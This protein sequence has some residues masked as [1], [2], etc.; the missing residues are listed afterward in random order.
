[1]SLPLLYFIFMLVAAAHALPIAPLPSAQTSPLVCAFVLLPFPLLAAIK[2]TYL[3]HRRGQ[4][5]H[6]GI[7]K[8]APVRLLGSPR[9]RKTILGRIHSGYLIG[10]LGSPD[11]ETRIQCRIDKVERYM[12]QSPAD[13]KPS[14][15]VLY[16][17]ILAHSSRTSSRNR[18]TPNVSSHR[19]LSRSRSLSVSC[20]DLQSLEAPVDITSCAI[21]H[22]SSPACPL[23]LSRPYLAHLRLRRTPVFS[24]PTLMQIMEPVLSSWYDETSSKSQDSQ[25]TR[26]TPPFETPPTSPNSEA[27]PLT[28]QN[29]S[30]FRKD[31]TLSTS[32]SLL[33]G[34]R[35]S[36]TVSV[37]E[38][39]STP[40]PPPVHAAQS[41]RRSCDALPG[42]WTNDSVEQLRLLQSPTYR[43]PS[44]PLNI[45]VVTTT[46]RAPFAATTRPLNV[47]PKPKTMS[48]PS[49]TLVHS[50]SPLDLFSGKSKRGKA[51]SLQ[52]RKS[53][54]PTIGPSPLRH[55]V[56]IETSV[57]MPTFDSR[58]MSGVY[59][60]TPTTV[61]STTRA[62]WELDD[63][64]RDGQ[65]DVDAV[66]AALGLGLVM[67]LGS[68]SG[69][70]IPSISD[71]T[72]SDA[73]YLS[74]SGSP[75]SGMGW[76]RAREVGNITLQI[77]TPG[78]QLCAI[79]EEDDIVSVA[80]R[81][82]SV[83]SMLDIDM[84]LQGVEQDRQLATRGDSFFGS[85]T[86]LP[87]APSASDGVEGTVWEDE[88]SWRD[89][90]SFR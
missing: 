28:K 77:R 49:P 65:L 55:S 46:Y 71:S 47:V 36:L 85:V 82:H 59:L 80:S 22:P 87:Q 24:S 10:C 52:R 63:L 11:W 88:Q 54:S 53:G 4:S 62:S 35:S 29:A 86:T 18:T 48:P 50:M 68:L 56:A 1:M 42:D 78:A 58:P 9:P 61:T 13:P 73:V 30:V 17:R 3:R 67:G 51:M 33:I 23:L 64:V 44:T 32:S 12:R 40:V 7:E 74:S 45:E 60:T 8:M 83:G 16:S 75:G 14:S 81:P 2:Y 34:D 66:S 90:V 31:I 6:E 89:T 37:F 43:S 84:R 15:A 19:S 72:S 70:N 25:G 57:S 79:P 69:D 39:P 41:R 26:I 20:L 76:G 5:I 21:V 27:S 38:A